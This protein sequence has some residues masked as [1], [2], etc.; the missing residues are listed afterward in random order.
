[1]GLSTFRFF[2]G[3][4]R[5]ARVVQLRHRLSRTPIAHIPV[6]PY[7]A[8]VSEYRRA[9]I[10]G[11]RSCEFGRNIYD[12]PHSSYDLAEIQLKREWEFGFTEC[13]NTRQEDFVEI[14]TTITQTDEQCYQ[15]GWATAQLGL[16]LNENPHTYGS[17]QFNMWYVGWNDFVDNH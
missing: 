1:M 4:L 14:D 7:T 5:K 10:N 3:I 13:F 11:W 6:P 8:T 16:P 9:F 2:K 17:H 15:E 12:C